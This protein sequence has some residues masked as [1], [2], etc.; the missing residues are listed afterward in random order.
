MLMTDKN[1]TLVKLQ[2]LAKKDFAF[3]GVISELKTGKKWG[4][5][6]NSVMKDLKATTAIVQITLMPDSKWWGLTKDDD[7]QAT[8]IAKVCVLY[9]SW[10]TY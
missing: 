8:S 4:G 3:Y 1:Q 10:I 7:R 6:S 2:A 9:P 5:L